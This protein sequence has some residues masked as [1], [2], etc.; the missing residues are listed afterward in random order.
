VPQA[1]YVGRPF[2]F[3]D[4][5]PVGVKVGV[6]LAGRKREPEVI[7]AVFQGAERP[8]PGVGEHLQH[9]RVFAQRLRGEGTDTLA[10]GQRDQVLEQQRADTAVVHVIGDRH[11]DLG[12]P[13]PVSQFVGAASHHFAIQHGQQRGMIRTGIAAYPAGLLLGRGRA[14]AEKAQVKVVRGHPGVQLPHRGEVLRPRG[15]DLD[16][17]A[18]GQQS[19]DAGP[20]SCAHFASRS[21]LGTPC[22][23]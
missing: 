8:Q 3:G 12:R 20:G 16:R 4:R 11:G 5:I 23:T 18:V 6:A 13:G 10:A 21:V 19:I 2:S 1:R 7:H 9:Q 22:L 15:P 17:G 14:H